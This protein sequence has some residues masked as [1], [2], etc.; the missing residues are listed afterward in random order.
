MIQ[1]NVQPASLTYPQLATIVASRLVLNAIFRVV[2]PLVPFVASYF[3]V[4]ARVATW[5][6]TIQVLAGL[7]SPLGGWLGDRRGYRR[8]MMLG[9]AIVLAGTIGVVVAGGLLSTIAA[10]GLVGLG[11]AIY[12]PAMQAYVSEL[13]PLARRGWALG[14]VELSWSLAGIVAV[15]PLVAL[16]QWTGDLRA[17]FSVLAAMIL[18]VL[19]LSLALLPADQPRSRNDDGPSQSLRRV[20]L[21]PAL[22]SLLIFFWLVLCAEEILFIAQAPWLASDF[23]A[24]PQQIGNTL[25]VFGVGELVGAG[26]STLF[27][28]R[29]GIVRATL[30]GFTGAAI[31]YLLFPLLVGGW[32]SYLL[33]FMLFGLAF[34]FAI[35]AS[36]ALASSVNPAARGTIMAAAALAMTSGRAGGSRIGIPLLE[37]TSLVVNGVVAAGLTLSGVVVA[38]IGVRPRENEPES[39]ETE[40]VRVL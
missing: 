1:A 19:L 28:D 9:L 7:A 20:L 16:V 4:P 6:V 3:G 30:A 29:I 31:I 35:V 10:F 36:F 32:S 14:I 23:G 27:T 15:P 12:Q 39:S 21:Q 25:F 26:L 11:M 18:V 22:W 13:T 38:A 34:E 2:Y 40:A 37:S 24:T 8:T 33:L 17:P 5:L